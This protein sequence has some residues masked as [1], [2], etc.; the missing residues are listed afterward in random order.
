MNV[1]FRPR[2]QEEKEPAVQIREVCCGQREQQTQWPRG[3]EPS[4]HSR[5]PQKARVTG[6]KWVK[7]GEGSAGN[8][9]IPDLVGPG[10]E[11]RFYS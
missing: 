6:G 7:L 9:V 3:L 2:L 1:T 10:E 8:I 11:T 4:T 5:N